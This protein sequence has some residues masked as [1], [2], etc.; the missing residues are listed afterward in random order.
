VPVGNAS[1]WIPDTGSRAKQA[2]AWELVKFLSSP[3]A[4]AA[5]TVGTSGGFIPVRESSLEAPLRQLYA[6]N[7]QLEVPYD[8]LQEGGTG[9]AAVGPVIGDYAMP[10]CARPSAMG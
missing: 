2:A 1:L 5:F 10:A 4:Y 9:A 8:Q 6:E 3:E 7:P